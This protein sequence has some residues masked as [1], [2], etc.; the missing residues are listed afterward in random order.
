MDLHSRYCRI[1]CLLTERVRMRAP[2]TATRLRKQREARLRPKQAGFYI[3][4]ADLLAFIKG[5]QSAAA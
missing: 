1:K 5:E 2:A 3:I 4:N